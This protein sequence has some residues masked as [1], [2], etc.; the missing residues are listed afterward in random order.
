VVPKSA[1]RRTT[2][3]PVIG[4]ASL[5]NWITA[6]NPEPV[7]PDPNPPPDALTYRPTAHTAAIVRARDR[8]CRFP[9]CRVPAARC[10]LDHIIAFDHNDPKHGG[11]TTISNLQS[12]CATHH[13][14]KTMNLWHAAMLPGAAIRWTGSTGHTHITIP[15]GGITATPPDHTLIP[16]IG[17]GSQKWKPPPPDPEPAPF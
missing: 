1:W 2:L 16:T 8:H 4:T 13:M 10:Q 3:G 11:Q 17:N 5:T 12:L 7:T 9:G 14:L 6:A 15:G